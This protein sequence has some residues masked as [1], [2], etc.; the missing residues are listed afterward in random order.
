M[1][2]SSQPRYFP[3]PARLPAKCAAPKRSTWLAQCPLAVARLVH[4]ADRLVLPRLN[5]KIDWAP[6]S[7]DKRASRGSR[8]HSYHRTIH[9]GREPCG[10]AAFGAYNKDG[11]GLAAP[12]FMLVHPR[13]GWKSPNGLRWAAGAGVSRALEVTALLGTGRHA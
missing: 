7:R 5:C 11:R 10:L 4:P 8:A 9:G 3:W 13:P 1:P 2:E 12:L 6:C